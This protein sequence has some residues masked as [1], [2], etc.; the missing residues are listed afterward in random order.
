MEGRRSVGSR[1]EERS[2]GA[3]VGGEQR[4]ETTGGIFLSSRRHLYRVLVGASL[5]PRV[6]LGKY[7]PIDLGYTFTESNSRKGGHYLEP[8]ADP[9]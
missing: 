9:R 1:G 8:I 5:L 3:P 2:G 7:V 6:T 4:E